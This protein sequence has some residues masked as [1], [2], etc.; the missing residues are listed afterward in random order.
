MVLI[1]WII[2]AILVVS[3]VG[4]ARKG[5]VVEA[6]SL[7]GLVLGL[8]LASWNY[9][10]VTPWVSEWI[11]QPQIAA[12]TSFLAIALGVMVIAGIAGRLVRWS[13]KSVGLG[14]A[15][16]LFGAIFGFVKGCVLVTIGVM[17][18]AAFFP[19]TPWLKDSRLAPYFLSMAHA[20]TVVTPSDLGARIRS[21]VRMIRDAQ[22][23][24]LK[25]DA[26]GVPRALQSDNSTT[27]TTN[28]AWNERGICEA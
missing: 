10:A 19:R 6:F 7:A 8:L 17:A 13:V 20:T 5:F 1:D 14:F 16:R 18:L 4:A 9:K 12:A 15:D 2:V 11:H 28:R 22:P 24:W 25:L 27:R 21:G 23:I 3:V 26:N